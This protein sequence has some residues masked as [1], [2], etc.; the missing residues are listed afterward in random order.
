M[1]Q[2]DATSSRNA[3]EAGTTATWSHV[4]G[5]GNQ[6]ALIVTSKCGNGKSISGITYNG[7]AL[8]KAV[9]AVY[10]PDGM[11]AEIWYLIAPDTGTHNVVI[12]FSASGAE[13]GSG[14]V[15]F[16][17]AHQS[18]LIGDTDVKDGG[19]DQTPQLTLT[20][21]ANGSYIV[22]IAGENSSGGSGTTPD[23]GQT[24]IFAFNS[25]GA[26]STG[27]SYKYQG[28]QGNVTTGWTLAS[29]SQTVMASAEIKAAAT[30]AFDAVS[31]GDATGASSL[32]FSHTCASN[33]VLL[34]AVYVETASASIS[35]VTYNG[36]AMTL[37][38]AGTAGNDGSTLNIYKLTNPASG[39]NNVVVTFSGNCNSHA[40]SASFIGAS[41]TFTSTSNT[42]TYSGS[43][44]R[45]S[46]SIS[47]ATDRI[48]FAVSGIN[49]GINS[50]VS[51][52]V[53]TETGSQPSGNKTIVGGRAMGD[54]TSTVTWESAVSAWSVG[55]VIV[56]IQ[57]VSAGPAN[58]KT[59]DGLA[60]ANV[61]TVDGL[62]IASV[63]T[64]DGLN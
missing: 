10:A 2:V 56:D 8:T 4:V 33:A 12:T 46:S 38:Q 22:D 52:V 59:V 48:V 18:S 26:A 37:Q 64:I 29:N 11:I 53:G 47:S 63:K 57:Q 20:T 36:V 45:F 30:L 16:F 1:L 25:G 7:V 42:G 28:A 55:A 14:A 32:T 19:V 39:A 15:S 58:V 44:L 31:G 62:A 13:H 5:S 17:G 61:K 60:I 23:S 43:P 41:G 21:T 54:A 6:R 34:V 49:N 27:S 9:G 24:A 40:I 50:Q 51:V 3:T 35:S